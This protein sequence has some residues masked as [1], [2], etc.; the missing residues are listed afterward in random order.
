[1]MGMTNGDREG[2]SGIGRVDHATWQQGFDHHLHLLFGSVPCPNNGFFDHIWGILGN[3]KAMA[4]GHQQRHAPSLSHRRRGS[5]H[6][7]ECFLDG[8]FIG[9]KASDNFIQ[10]VE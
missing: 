9:F 6:I 1:M 8:H 5:V 4:R 2:I 3:R 7:D 10:S